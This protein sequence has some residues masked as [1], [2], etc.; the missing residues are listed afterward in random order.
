[1][2]LNVGLIYAYRDPISYHWIYTGSIQKQTTL[3]QRHVRHLK[4]DHLFD[5]WLQFMSYAGQNIQ[6]EIMQYVGYDQ[7]D[8]LHKK[9]NEWMKRLG[10]LRAEGGLNQVLAGGPDHAAMGRIGGKKGWRRHYELYGCQL[11]DEGRAR[12]QS[13]GGKNGKGVKKGPNGANARNKIYGNPATPDG[14][15][16][17]GLRMNELYPNHARELGLKY[18]NKASH[19]DKVRAGYAAAHKRYHVLRNIVDPNCE[20]CREAMN[21]SH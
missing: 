16:N 15:R 13:K 3:S 9:E 12:G 6:P 11:T 1:M 19:A 14:C 7:V 8:E 18:G 4:D 20:F 21:G 2:E 10:T 17:G 5:I